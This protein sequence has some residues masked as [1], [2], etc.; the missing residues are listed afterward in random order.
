MK[1]QR[2]T[3]EQI[4]GVLREQEAGAKALTCAANTEYRKRPFITGKP[5]TAVD[6]ELCQLGGRS[7]GDVVRRIKKGDWLISTACEG[8][9][10]SL[11]WSSI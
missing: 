6:C 8:L 9:Q 7:Q 10:R 5:N 3:E 11:S 1:T 4:I 2:F